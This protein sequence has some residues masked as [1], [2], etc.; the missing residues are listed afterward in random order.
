VAGQLRASFDFNTGAWK[1][2]GDVNGDGTADFAIH[3]VTNGDLP[4]IASDFLL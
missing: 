1:V 3:V 2:E 4:L